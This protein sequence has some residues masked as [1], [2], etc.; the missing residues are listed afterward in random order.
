MKKQM[1]INGAKYEF[2]VS[3]SVVCRHIYPKY[4]DA[5]LLILVNVRSTTIVDV[6]QPIRYDILYWETWHRAELQ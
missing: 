4:S 3:K 5:K 2:N 6:Y 1:K